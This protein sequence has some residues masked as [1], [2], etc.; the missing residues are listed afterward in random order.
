MLC[1]DEK[2]QVQVLDRSRTVL[3]MMPGM[4]ERRTHDYFRH[5][6]P[7]V[8]AFDITTGV[9]SQIHCRHRAAAFKKFLIKIDKPSPASSTSTLCATITPST[10][11]RRSTPGSHGIPG[12]ASTPTSSSWS[13]RSNASSACSPTNSSAAAH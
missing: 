12:S 8:A 3:P 11:P 2:S 9:I 6:H 5:G 4:P 7:P 10:G 1:V 13:T